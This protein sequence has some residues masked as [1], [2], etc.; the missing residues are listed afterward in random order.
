MF[1]FFIVISFKKYNY[2]QG[3]KREFFESDSSKTSHF[4]SNTNGMGVDTAHFRRA[5]VVTGANED[6]YKDHF[7]RSTHVAVSVQKLLEVIFGGPEISQ[8]KRNEPCL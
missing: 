6:L 1:I 2:F 4:V 8:K 7:V 5:A 3:L